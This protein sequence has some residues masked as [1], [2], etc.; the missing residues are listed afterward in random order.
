MIKEV[1]YDQFKK[2]EKKFYKVN[3][4]MY[5]KIIWVNKLFP[6]EFGHYLNELIKKLTPKKYRS[7]YTANV[8]YVLTEDI[9][10][11]TDEWQNRGKEARKHYSTVVNEW[12]GKEIQTD[13]GYGNDEIIGTIKNVIVTLDDV[14]YDCIDKDGNGVWKTAV[15]KVKLVDNGID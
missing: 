1:T 8:Y 15:S 12:I 9:I 13:S 10:N 2:F 6:N 4:S 5:N 14:Y 11:T 3:N 7:I